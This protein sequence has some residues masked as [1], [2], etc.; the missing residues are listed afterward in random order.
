MIDETTTREYA[1]LKDSIV[2]EVMEN[3]PPST[4]L[5]YPVSQVSLFIATISINFSLL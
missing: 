3:E 4:S 2:K 1:L 5:L